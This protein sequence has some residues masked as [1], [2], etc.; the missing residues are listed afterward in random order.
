[1]AVARRSGGSVGFEQPAS[2]TLL[3]RLAGSWR[4]G[5]KLPS[6]DDVRRQ[7]ELTGARRMVF[8]T[9]GIVGWD[10]SLLT[11]LGKVID[12]NDQSRVD[13]D[14]SGLPGGV[15]R[16]LTLASAVP[17]RKDTGSGRA[18]SWLARV[19]I[20]V[21]AFGVQTRRMLAFIGDTVACLPRLLRGAAKF[22]RVDFLE[23]LQDCGSRALPI[24]TLISFLV[25]VILAYVGAIQL[26]QFG[27]QVYVA[28]LVGIAM[29]R[30]MGAMMA[31][32]IMAGRTG[33]AFAAQLGTMQ[34][35]EEIDALKTLGISPMEF[36]V[37]PRMLALALMMPLLCIYAD[38]M[39]ILGGAAVG[40]GL[41]DIGPAEYYLRTATAIGINDALAGLIKGSIFGVLV[42][43][44]GCLRGMESGRSASAVGA[45]A[46]S[47]VVTG[48]VS[49]IVADA[50]LTVIF[51]ILK[52]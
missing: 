11:F 46:T 9:R 42:A 5:D 30:E 44:A 4:L 12:E 21:A 14:R 31:A 26:R 35:N 17:A 33:A 28:D 24:V 18:P 6:P 23:I 39:G 3:V 50:A 47:A 1:V 13:T 32:I 8:D 29:T 36:L 16:L 7:V 25:G 40:L 10:S 52:F 43:I 22:R 48:I 2:S 27:A 37:L 49:V 45:A 34:V 38:L 51:D 15:Q 20:A 41:L 19:G